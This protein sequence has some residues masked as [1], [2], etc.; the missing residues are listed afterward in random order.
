MSA[1]RICSRVVETVSPSERVRA[2]A[3]RMA[4]LDVGTLVVMSA[5]EPSHAVGIVTDRDI[6]TRCVAAGLD[7]EKALVSEVMTQPIHTVD[8]HT[9]IETAL[10]KMARGGTRRLIVTGPDEKLVGVLS[11]DDALDLLVEETAAIGR[12]LDKQQPHIPA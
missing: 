12:L 3:R 1:G 7:P 4:D 5:L 10:S 6:V 8:E 11:L 9:S 2:A